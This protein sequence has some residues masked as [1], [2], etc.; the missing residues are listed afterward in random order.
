MTTPT[1]PPTVAARDAWERLAAGFDER[2]TPHTMALGSDIVHRLGIGPGTKVLDVAAGSGALS[3]PAARAGAQVIAVDVAPTMIDRL[4]QRA[5]DEGLDIVAEVGDGTALDLDDDT[6]D[7]TVSLNGISL[8]GDL[9]GGLREAVRVTRPGGEVAIGTF[10]AMPQVEFVAFFF[11]A[12]RA[13]AGP[14]FAPPPGPLPP[15]RLADPDV[16]R[17][18]L[19]DVGLGSVAVDPLTWTTEFASAQHY[20]DTVLTSNPVTGRLL[21]GLDDAQRDEL[22]GVLTGML[23]ERSGGDGAAVLHSRMLLGRGVV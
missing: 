16:L 3:L 8:F 18:T 13:A 11:G 9:D 14:S 21:A 12:L 19:Q 5:A 10:A 4:R 1:Q 6:V 22:R 23:R 15:F 17:A 2:T 20:L 7:V